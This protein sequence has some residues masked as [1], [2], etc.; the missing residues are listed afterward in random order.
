MTDIKK[1]IAFPVKTD[2]YGMYVWDEES[3]MLLDH[4]GDGNELITKFAVDALNAAHG[5]RDGKPMN[6][7]VPFMFP[8]RVDDDA[9]NIIDANG[10]FVLRIRGWGRLQRL[11]HDEAV[12]AQRDIGQAFADAMNATL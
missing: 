6:D 7:C 11:G 10:Q 4:H 9:L 5:H 1:L 2:D 12:A 3:H 8:V